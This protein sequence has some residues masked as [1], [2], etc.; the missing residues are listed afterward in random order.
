[1][2]I[3]I[4]SINKIVSIEN[5]YSIIYILNS[6][7]YKKLIFDL[8]EEMIVSKSATN[9]CSEKEILVLHNPYDINLNDT[10]ILK[11][12]YKNTE[13]S[14]KKE[15]IEEI[16]IITSETVKLLS[17]ISYESECELT[18]EPE[19]DYSKFLSAFSLK[20]VET[21]AN[22]Y[23]EK[24]IKYIKINA[25]LFNIKVVITFGLGYVLSEEEKQT[26]NNELTSLGV[27]V[28]DFISKEDYISNQKL[29]LIDDDY[30]VI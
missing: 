11:E 18:F 8:D 4:K 16:G 10:K 26:L 25:S 3:F 2:Q 23:L 19:F 6:I 28:I 1:M 21:D 9:S 30:C 7:Q 17:T 14:I 13:R 20:F 5:Y 12:L 15:M 27:F 24:F 29:L 22:N